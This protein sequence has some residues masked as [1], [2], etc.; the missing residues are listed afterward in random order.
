MIAF[1]MTTSLVTRTCIQIRRRK[2]K[3][4]SWFAR[5]EHQERKIVLN[6]MKWRFPKSQGYPPIIQIYIYNYYIFVLKAMVYGISSSLGNTKN[7][8]VP[9]N[10]FLSR[11]KSHVEATHPGFNGLKIARCSVTISTRK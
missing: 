5:W 7:S 6:S 10:P 11:W 8:R 1:L 9:P 2:V 3:C 4:R